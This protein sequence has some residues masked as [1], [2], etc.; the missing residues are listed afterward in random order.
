M[1]SGEI[2]SS[3]MKSSKPADRCVSNSLAHINTK[4]YKKLTKSSGANRQNSSSSNPKK[5]KSLKIST[6]KRDEKDEKKNVLD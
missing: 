2:D 4:I 1:E 3:D 5:I 6:P